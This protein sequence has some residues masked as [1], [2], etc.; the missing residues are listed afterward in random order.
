MV[1]SMAKRSA[2]RRKRQPD[3]TR[4]KLLHAAFDEIYRRGFQAASLETILDQAGLTKGALY[5]H[6]PDKAALGHAVVD[7]VV[8]GLLL[9]RWLGVLQRQQGDPITAL[10]GMLEERSTALTSHEV[11]LGCPLNNLAQEMA[12]VDEKFRRRIDAAFERWIAGFARLLRQGQ[13]DGTI[14]RDVKPEPLA[15]FLVAAIE[16]SFG[17]AKSARSSALL[18]S[19][20]KVLAGLLE[21]LR[22]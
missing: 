4:Q 18:R 6:F 9:E 15:A 8:T 21:G 1:L 20:L 14:R 22:S 17:L 11:E 19:N 3:V 13:K 16:G 2:T 7:D 12:P 10:Q 5:H